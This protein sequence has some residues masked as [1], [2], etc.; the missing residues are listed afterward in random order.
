MAVDVKQLQQR[1]AGLKAE[2]ETWENLWHD[3]RDYEVPDLGA[4]PGERG[5]EGGKRYTRLYDAE[6]ADSAD[7]LAAGLLAGVS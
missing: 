3:I 7:I 6:A 1:L 4:F 2:R 5:Y